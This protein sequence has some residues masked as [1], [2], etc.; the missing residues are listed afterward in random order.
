MT[1]LYIIFGLVVLA[2][3]IGAALKIGLWVW[4]MTAVFRRHP[5]QY[6]DEPVVRPGGAG[7]VKKWLAI[8]GTI[9]GLV[10][11]TMGILEKCEDDDPVQHHYTQPYRPTHRVIMGQKCCTQYGQCVMMA[12]AVVGSVCTCFGLAGM[13]QGTVCR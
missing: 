8:L 7:T 6:I 12:P 5:Q 11:T 9:L 13:A 1:D 3:A 2:G 10:S 4:I